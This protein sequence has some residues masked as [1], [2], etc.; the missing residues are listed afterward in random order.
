M[1]EMDRPEGMDLVLATEGDMAPEIDILGIE[2][3]AVPSDKDD[4]V[5]DSLLWLILMAYPP[6]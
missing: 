1:D 5:D 6:N 2:D 4:E 3:D